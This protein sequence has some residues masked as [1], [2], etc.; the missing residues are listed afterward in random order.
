MKR[1]IFTSIRSKLLFSFFSIIILLCIA[2][3][4]TFVMQ[5]SV[6]K[7]QQQIRTKLHILDQAK[8]IENN[9]SE[10]YN[11]GFLMIMSDFS[12]DKEEFQEQ[13]TARISDVNHIL[14]ALKGELQDADSFSELERIWNDFIIQSEETLYTTTDQELAKAHYRYLPYDQLR[15]AIQQ[16]VEV[17]QAEIRAI[18]AEM[19]SFTEI[20]NLVSVLATLCAVVIGLIWSWILSNRISTPIQQLRTVSNRIAQGDLSMEAVQE[21]TKDE[22]ADLIKASN[23]MVGNLKAFINLVS[24]ASVEVAA[25][26]KQL[27]ANTEVT[28]GSAGDML[29]AIKLVNQSMLRQLENCKESVNAIQGLAIE[30]QNVADRSSDTAH[31]SQMMAERA[32]E[33]FGSIHNAMQQM[34]S[35]Q[36]AMTSSNHVAKEL[37]DSAE[38]IEVITNLISDIAAQTNMLALN[39]SIEAARAGE[40]GKGFSVVANEVKKLAERTGQSALEITELVSWMQGNSKA[41]VQALNQVSSE[42]QKG[43]EYVNDAGNHFDTIHKTSEEVAGQVEAISAGA[44]EISAGFEELTATFEELSE[45]AQN[46]A[47]QSNFLEGITSQQLALNEQVLGASKRMSSLSEDLEKEIHQFKL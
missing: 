26:S 9:I 35:I 10:A 24:H 3:L 15:E 6:A 32:A 14:Q 43:I 28:T 30:V 31:Y 22:I 12:S 25:A 47:D 23:L 5:S 45:S 39:A 17:Q 29:K 27:A 33:G 16:V 19:E 4:T 40:S 34:A 1:S 13:Y 7:L 2:T 20:S 11:N 18:E 37:Y 8:M 36:S 44:E 38:K 46:S 21:S 42:I 41:S